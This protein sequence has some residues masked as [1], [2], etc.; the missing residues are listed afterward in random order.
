MLVKAFNKAVVLWVV[1][2]RMVELSAQQMC[3]G[4][5]LSEEMCNGLLDQEIQY[6]TN[7]WAQV[8][9][10]VSNSRIVSGHLV[11]YSTMVRW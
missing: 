6:V 2:C 10:V 3:N 7:A 5:P 9:V 8:A 11:K 1:N 4:D